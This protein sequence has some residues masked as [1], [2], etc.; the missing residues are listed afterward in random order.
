MQAFLATLLL[1]PTDLRRYQIVVFATSA[2]NSSSEEFAQ[3]LERELR[4][5]SYPEHIASM[6]VVMAHRDLD[7]GCWFLLDDHVN[8]RGHQRI[9]AALQAA[10]GK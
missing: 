8:S 7:D 3:E 1:S 5:A 6:K 10:I 2:W 4:T 9:A